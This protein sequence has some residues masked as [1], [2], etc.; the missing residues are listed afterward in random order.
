MV[1]KCKACGEED[2]ADSW[3]EATLAKCISRAQRRSIV[4]IDSN[5]AKNHP[6]RYSY[7]CPSC[8]EFMYRGH[9]KT[10][11]TKVE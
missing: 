5:K 2:F 11:E 10:R 6:M 8:G 3:M 4:P 1:F 7:V 9:L